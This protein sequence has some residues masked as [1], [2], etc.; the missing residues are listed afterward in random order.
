[1]TADLECLNVERTARD[2]ENK[3]YAVCSKEES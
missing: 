1:M 3:E 2:N